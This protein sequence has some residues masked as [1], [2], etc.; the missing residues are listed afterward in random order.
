MSTL[1]VQ[2]G[3]MG[4]WSNNHDEVATSVQGVAN[5]AA[6]NPSLSDSHGIVSQPFLAA[7]SATD[8]ARNEA[9]G[10]TQTASSAIAETLRKAQKAYEEGD[11]AG[12]EQI[13]A[14]AA[15]MAAAQGAGGGGGS[16][17]GSAMG[18]GGQGAS[19]MM[20]Q[21]GQ[22]AGQVMQG[23]TQPVQGLAQSLGQLPQQVMQSVQ[24]LTQ[25][26]GQGGGLAA[27]AGGGAAT[28]AAGA[29]ASGAGGGAPAGPGHPDKK[30]AER[31]GAVNP[32]A[33][34]GPDAHEK[35]P[36]EGVMSRERM[37]EMQG[38]PPEEP[39]HRPPNRDIDF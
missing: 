23:V 20:G 3:A 5:G 8:A 10:A 14:Q 24:G 28:G 1:T 22:M 16:A 26:A 12:A 35:A 19:Q 30:H 36:A 13:R 7:Q 27:G 32:D 25:A 31:D 34:A 21:F 15:Q 39:G 6:S 9:L 4:E 2:P 29:G 38:L 33:A 11:A 37:R 18:Q 17:A